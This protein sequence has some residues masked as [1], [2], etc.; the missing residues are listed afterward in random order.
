MNAADRK[1]QR[2]LQTDP[3]LARWW[4]RLEF[5]DWL[6]DDDPRNLEDNV[7]DEIDEEVMA[8]ALGT[9]RW[10]APWLARGLLARAGCYADEGVRRNSRLPQLLRARADAV[11]AAAAH[12]C[13]GGWCFGCSAAARHAAE[14]A[15]LYELAV[16]VRVVLSAEAAA[17]PALSRAA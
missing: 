10:V 16:R 5:L 13:G 3:D 4:Y 8:R 2:A 14:A 11:L 12:E 15:E 6:I 7:P 9:A 17:P 1:F